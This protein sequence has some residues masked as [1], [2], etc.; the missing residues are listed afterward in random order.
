MRERIVERANGCCEYC[1]SQE[2]FATQPFSVEHV[3]ARAKGGITTIE[4]LALAC[5]GCNNYKYDKVE[6]SDPVNGQPA[7]L[8]SPRVDH[9]A[10]HFVWSHDFALII[11]MTPTGRATVT[12]LRLN[13][14][15]VVRLRRI[16]YLHGQHPPA[17]VTSLS[18]SQKA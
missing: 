18:G 11:G 3:V 12:Q 13:R 2:R 17:G 10:E 4:N 14:D 7:L 8:Y 1:H 9:W 5:Q 6:A 16:L 15:G